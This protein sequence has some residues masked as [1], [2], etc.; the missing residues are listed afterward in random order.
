VVSQKKFQ[1]RKP[2]FSNAWGF[3]ELEQRKNV[4]GEYSLHGEVVTENSPLLKGGR[5]GWSGAGHEHSQ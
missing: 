1:A 2:R 5:R 3:L 4:A